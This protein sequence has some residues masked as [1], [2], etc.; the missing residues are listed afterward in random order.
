MPNFLLVNSNEENKIRDMRNGYPIVAKVTAKDGSGLKSKYFVL[1]NGKVNIPISPD[2]DN[3][4]GRIPTT[5][6]SI[7]VE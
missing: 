7:D 6:K 1:E 4:I 3:H 5:V 2:V